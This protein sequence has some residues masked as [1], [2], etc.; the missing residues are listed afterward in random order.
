MRTLAYRHNLGELFEAWLWWG[1]AFF[2]KRA[3]KVSGTE[4]TNEEHKA[5]PCAVA[6]ILSASLT[7]R[8]PTAR[9]PRLQ[10]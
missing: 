2:I 7:G 5:V 8:I 10:V 1:Q 6:G 9:H 3:K 4:A